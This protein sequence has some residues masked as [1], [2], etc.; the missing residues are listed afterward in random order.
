MVLLEQPLVPHADPDL[1]TEG[2]AALQ[3]D[4]PMPLVADES[5]WDMEDLLRLA[6][7]VDG[8]NLKL[9]KTG[10]LSPALLMAADRPM[11]ARP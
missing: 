4:C 8:V 1:D 7:V 5:C 6:P 2:F 3:S 9:L 10:G 11:S